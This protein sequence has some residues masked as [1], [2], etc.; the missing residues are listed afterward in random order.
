MR[1]IKQFRIPIVILAVYLIATAALL[2]VG[3][4]VEKPAV[5]E[6]E[7]PFSVTY[8]YEGQT[9][10]VSGI[11][12][13]SAYYGPKYM[14]ETNVSWYGSVRDHEPGQDGFYMIRE[15][16][17]S[18]LAIVL[19]LDPAYL[20]GGPNA[21][22]P[23]GG[24]GDAPFGEYYGYAS[25][26]EIHIT[27][28]ARLEDMGLQIISWDSPKP[29]ENSFHPAGIMLSGEAA[30]YLAGIALAAMVACVL[31]VRKDSEVRYRGF[32]KAATVMNAL[33]GLIYFPFVLMFSVLSE[34]YAGEG[35]VDYGTY[36]L[37]A[38]T[39]LGIAVSIVLRR[40]GYSKAGFLAQFTGVIFLPVLMLASM[41]M[42]Y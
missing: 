16:D 4:R 39:L 15:T 6:A 30:A 41:L 18:T 13:C 32:D 28:P 20:M 22:Q 29:I 5:E 14:G 19:N 2:L 35:W 3:Y 21:V 12:E 27:D 23:N 33:I 26:E 40:K 25:D 24:A 17:D 34:L 11:Y 1:N 7:F 36:A 31:F 10:T 37:P 9:N 8:A 38:V 42:L